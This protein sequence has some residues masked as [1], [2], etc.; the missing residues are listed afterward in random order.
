[1]EPAS[2]SIRGD[3]ICVGSWLIYAAPGV[4]LYQNV[5]IVDVLELRSFRVIV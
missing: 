2:P 4:Q 5:P 3:P 1:M